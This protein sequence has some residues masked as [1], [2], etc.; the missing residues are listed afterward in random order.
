MSSFL[1][2]HTTEFILVPRLNRALNRKN[3]NVVPI[4]YW[5]SR[6]GNNLSMNL[7]KNEKVKIIALF[8]RRPK[9]FKKSEI[10]YGKIN[11][12]V[13]GFVNRASNLGIPTIAGL[14][15]VDSIKKL[16]D[17]CIVCWLKIINDFQNDLYFKYNINDGEIVFE[18]SPDNFIAIISE[19][20][21]G[22]LFESASIYNWEDASKIFRDLRTNFEGRSVHGFWGLRN[23]KPVYMLS[24]I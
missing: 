12:D 9:L 8:P 16:K 24:F 17:D 10:I 6:E 11:V 2:E 13:F 18:N 5:A 3:D 15:L 7:H 22:N 4:Y 19:A 1:S 14:P 21:L 20:E 23:Y